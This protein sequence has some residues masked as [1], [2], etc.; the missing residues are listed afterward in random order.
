MFAFTGG[1]MHLAPSKP[2]SHRAV[3]LP[4]LVTACLFA[5]AAGFLLHTSP[6][7]WLFGKYNAGYAIFL[8]ALFLAVIPA[9]HRLARFCAITHQGTSS[10]GKQIVIRP[11][12]KMT[13]VAI[14]ACGAF[15]MVNALIDRALRRQALGYNSN[16]F[17]PYLQNSPTPND[18]RLHVNRWG[19]RGDD[20]DVRKD[21]DVFRVFVFGGSTVYCGT[22]P[23]EQ[24]HCRLL[25]KRLRAAYPQYQ[26]E[27][28]NLG[29]EWHTSEHD[30]IKL[31]FLAQDFAP[32]LVVTFHAINDLVRSLS[33]DMFA[34][35]RYWPD[36]RHYHG[37]AANLATGGAKTPLLVRAAAGHWCSDL[38]FDTMQLNGPDGR[39]IK[40]MRLLFY[41]KT[42]EIEIHQWKSLA[43]F[44]RNL[45]DFVQIARAKGL[46]V[47]LATQPSLYRDDLTPDERRLLGFPLSHYFDGRRPSLHSMVDGM[48]QFNDVTRNVARQ[49]HVALV[50][51]DTRMPKT[52]EYL[53]DDVHYTAAGSALVGNAFADTII[54]SRLIDQVME[55]RRNESNPSPPLAPRATA[56]LQTTKRWQ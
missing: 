45:D 53:Y 24:T 38:R 32:D 8:A 42:Q 47:L 15:L 56:G 34:D 51:L 23:Y 16:V 55:A 18:P 9:L 25:E 44:R 33:P 11:R 27:V 1:A 22:L 26:V 37:G 43:A 30:T 21:A 36:Y 39:G 49:N 4:R 10:S 19:F 54:E 52:T 40:G 7:P 12:H 41:P 17:H 20:L 3:W 6:D 48:R 5:A 2:A 14:L 31:L 13:V 29:A 35:G 50:D 46:R 28:Q